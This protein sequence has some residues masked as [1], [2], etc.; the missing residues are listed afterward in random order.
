[1]EGPNETGKFIQDPAGY[2]T[3]VNRELRDKPAMLRGRLEIIL[4]YAQAYSTGSYQGCVA[5]AREMF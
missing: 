3:A 5:V 1:V 4:K 2:I